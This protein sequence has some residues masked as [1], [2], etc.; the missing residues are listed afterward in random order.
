MATSNCLVSDILQNIIFNVQQKKETRLGLKQ[1]ED[2]S[3]LGQL[4]L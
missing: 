2:E 1:L 3:F 4:Y